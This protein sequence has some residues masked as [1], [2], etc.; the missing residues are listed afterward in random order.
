[1][2]HKGAQSSAQSNTK[3]RVVKEMLLRQ[4]LSSF[5]SGNLLL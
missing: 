4:P 3:E 2:N 5:K 1:L